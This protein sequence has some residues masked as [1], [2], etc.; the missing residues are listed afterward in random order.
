MIMKA[1]YILVVQVICK[2]HCHIWEPHNP[3]MN[4]QSWMDTWIKQSQNSKTNGAKRKTEFCCG[5]E[6]VEKNY[7]AHI[8]K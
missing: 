2:I 5:A 8:Y 4:E 7:F 6:A 1:K 3:W